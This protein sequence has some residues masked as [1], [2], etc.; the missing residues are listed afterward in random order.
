MLEFH[1]KKSRQRKMVSASDSEQRIRFCLL[2]LVQRVQA[3][4]GAL[5]SFLENKLN[6]KILYNFKV[7]I[8]HPVN[9]IWQSL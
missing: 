9:A 3:E 7:G 5:K 8:L 4:E 1:R 2:I 6:I